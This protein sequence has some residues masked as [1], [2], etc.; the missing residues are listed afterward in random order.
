MRRG[1]TLSRLMGETLPFPLIRIPWDRDRPW[2]ATFLHEV[3]HNLQADLG[4]WVENRTA[5]ARRIASAEPEVRTIW[6][7]WHKEIFADLAAL[8]LGGPAVAWGMADFLAHPQSKVATYRPGGMHPTNVLRIPILAE[9]LRRMGF[10]AEAADLAR[11]WRELYPRRLGHRIPG[12]LLATA[13]A[14]TKAVVDEVAWQARRALAG[15][16]LGDVIRFDASDQAAI[17]QGALKLARG[18]VPQGLP[19]RFLVSASNYA[20]DAGADLTRLSHLVTNHLAGRRAA[21]SSHA[22]AQ[23]APRPLALAA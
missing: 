7:R 8:L 17:Q 12:R 22:A 16:A 2:Q 3:A 15:R 1:I 5:L 21:A 11:V 4:L 9:M 23:P 20:I 14:V 18:R 6:I 19:P 10:A 13:P